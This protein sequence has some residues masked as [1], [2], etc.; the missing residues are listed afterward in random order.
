MKAYGFTAFGGPENETMLDLPVPSP[1]PG[2]LLVRVRAAGVNPGD[3]KLRE[4][5]Y[6]DTALPAVLGREVAGT[7]V[8]AGPGAGGFAVG[9]TRCSAALRAWWAAGPSRRWCWRRSLRTVLR[10]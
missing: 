8:A 5:G 10:V 7:V 6:G 4:G 3:W 2:E 1:G 9:G